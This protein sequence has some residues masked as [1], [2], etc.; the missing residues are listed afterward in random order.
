MPSDR[1]EK[2]GWNI[3]FEVAQRGR[4]D[5]DGY[6]LVTGEFRPMDA[7]YAAL[8]EELPAER[9]RFRPHPFVS[10]QTVDGW[11]LAPP[12]GQDDI[13][14]L[15]PKALAVI[16]YDSISGCDAALYGVPSI[17]YGENAMARP[18]SWKSWAEFDKADKIPEMEVEDWANRLAYCQWSHDEIVK[19]DFWEH[20]RGRLSDD[21]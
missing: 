8:K 9:V 1:W 5:P 14:S 11:K 3:P 12:A 13:Q 2:H 15:F 6:L 4:F 18:V 19:G 7:W 21:T 16:S 17:T 10:G 20:L